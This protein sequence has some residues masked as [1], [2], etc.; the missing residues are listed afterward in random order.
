MAAP[1]PTDQV[2][3]PDDPG[4]LHVLLEQ[5]QSELDA[6]RAELAACQRQLHDMGEVLVE[7]NATDPV[8]GLKNRRA[9][10]RIM[11]QQ[12]ARTAR[13]QLPLAL[14]FVDIDH[15]KAFNLE[16][17]RAMGDAALQQVAQ[18]LQSHA[19]A[20]DYVVRFDDKKLAIVLPDTSGE[21]AYSVAE[22]A[23]NAVENLPWDHRPLTISL[24]IATTNSLSGSKTIMERAESALLQAKRKGRNCV[25]VIED[26]G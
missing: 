8:T 20:Y 18:A 13:S 6:C 5:T 10:N 2:S 11:S 12:T 22:R 14:A 19:R 4:Q 25:V 15:F 23:R 9:F 1:L 17:G 26:R 21:A 16:F 3:S 7:Q 24:G